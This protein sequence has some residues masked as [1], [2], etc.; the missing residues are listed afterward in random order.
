M[1]GA[2]ESSEASS[3][4]VPCFHL[5]APRRFVTTD[6]TPAPLHGEKPEAVWRPCRLRS[7][8]DLI[9]LRPSLQREIAGPGKG[10]AGKVPFQGNV[11]H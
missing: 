8:Y 11:W 5:V 10:F 3:A 4:P 1:S 2:P 7:V 9:P 6:H